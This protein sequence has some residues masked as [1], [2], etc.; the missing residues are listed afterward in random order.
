MSKSESKQEILKIATRLFA[1]Q[2]FKGTT[3]QSIADGVGMKKPSLLYHYP[4]KKAI[5]QAVIQDLK[6]SWRARLPEILAAALKG[7]DQFTAIFGEVVLFF[8]ADPNRALL[9]MRE[10]VERPKQTSEHIGSG[11]KPWLAMISESISK[12]K[13]AGRVRDDIDAEAYLIECIILLVGTF[14]AA[15]MAGLV[16]DGEGSDARV[17]RQLNEMIRIAKAGLF[18]DNAL[19]KDSSSS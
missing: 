6:Y 1:R 17:D 16:F 19:S 12:G 13:E 18:N 8:K 14:A 9:I 3:L 2:G 4:S 7:T 11:V 5:H 15:D 10:V